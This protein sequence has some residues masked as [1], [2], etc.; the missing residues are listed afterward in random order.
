MKNK[1]GEINGI[2]YG[3]RCTANQKWYIGQTTRGIE[4]RRQEHLKAARNNND[5]TYRC[6][7]HAAIRKYGA[8]SFEWAVLESD[9][10]TYDELNEAEKYWIKEKN[11]RVKD[12]GY[13]MNAGGNGSPDHRKEFVRW[14]K[15]KTG[16][17]TEEA[18]RR[19]S[20]GRRGIPVS[21]EQRKKISATL[22]GRHL[23]EEH[24][25]HM[26]AG[27]KGHA[28]PESA[29]KRISEAH[30]GQ[31]LSEEHKKKISAANRGRIHTEEA[32]RHMSESKK[33]K[34]HSEEHRM[35]ITNA[36]RK[37]CSKPVLMYN[38]NGDFMAEFPSVNAAADYIGVDRR[39]VTQVLTGKHKTT[40]GGSGNKNAG[41]TFRYK[42]EN[43][44]R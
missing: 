13:N 16:C 32:R 33:G 28:C 11:A 44:D 9:I 24:K 7:F 25:M 42:N 36:I 8:D 3:V 6:V 29:R 23:S 38:W 40:G 12:G 17:Y 1:E 10:H 20:E 41:Y 26:S 18:R 21:E 37:I 22:T 4:K 34:P 5:H 19:M 15:G 31:R 39:L 14:N 43:P 35:N 30:K 2:I 27:L